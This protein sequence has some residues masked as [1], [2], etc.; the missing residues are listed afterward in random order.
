MKFFLRS[1]LSGSE[2]LSRRTKFYSAPAKYFDMETK[3]IVLL[4]CTDDYYRFDFIK[5]EIEWAYPIHFWAKI[6]MTPILQG[7]LT[8]FKQ[9]VALPPLALGETEACEAI[10][11]LTNAP[12]MELDDLKE[13]PREDVFLFES[14]KEQFSIEEARQIALAT[15]LKP[16]GD[17][18]IYVI[19]QAD[20]ITLQAANSLLK[21]FEESQ[22]G[23]L[24]LLTVS[25]KEALLETIASRVLFISEN[26]SETVTITDDDLKEK[27]QDFAQ[28]SHGGLLSYLAVQKVNKMEALAI[29]FEMERA[30]IRH[31]THTPKIL[32]KIDATLQNIAQVNVSAYWILDTCIFE[33]AGEKN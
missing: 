18:A 17:T 26:L 19:R 10:R 30:F 7:L 16:Y 3:A 2:S 32:S 13:T 9:Q 11:F 28:G 23:R 22:S 1:F 4:N 33:I 25:N 21:L 15:G 24:F 14:E 31:G 5:K 27:I 12:I 6:N 8:K 20:K 29:L